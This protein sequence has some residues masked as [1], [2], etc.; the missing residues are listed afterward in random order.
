MALTYHSKTCEIVHGAMAR[1]FIAGLLDKPEMLA[2]D[3]LCLSGEKPKPDIP[4]IE[5]DL[6]SAL[7]IRALRQRE[8][9]SLTVFAHCLDVEP[10]T[11][12][13][14][15]VGTQRPDARVGRLLQIIARDGLRALS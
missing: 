1:L 10:Q 12:L 6:R 5:P 8:G 3:R 4:Q 2:F 7:A 15:E 14:W 9:A 11:V 13:A